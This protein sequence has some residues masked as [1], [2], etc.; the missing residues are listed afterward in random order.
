MK[1]ENPT[2]IFCVKRGHK[3]N[4]T[5]SFYPYAVLLQIKTQSVHVFLNMQ[6]LCLMFILGS[7]LLGNPGCVSDLKPGGPLLGSAQWLMSF[8]ACAQN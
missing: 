6:N 1:T 3:E 8:P 2:D 5:K 7:G 4:G